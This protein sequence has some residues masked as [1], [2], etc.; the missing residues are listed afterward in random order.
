M[1][2]PRIMTTAFMFYLMGFDKFEGWVGIDQLCPDNKLAARFHESI[3]RYGSDPPM[4]PNTIPCSPT[5]PH[6]C[7]SRRSSAHRC[8][9]AS[10]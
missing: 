2:P 7:S 1:D 3:E 9:A 10:A 5:T 6:V 8:S 4:W